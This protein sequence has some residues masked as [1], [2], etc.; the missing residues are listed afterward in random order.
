MRFDESLHQLVDK[1]A[2]KSVF[3]PVLGRQALATFIENRDKNLFYG[4]HRSWQEADEAA[5]RFGTTGYDNQISSDMYDARIRL[6]QHDYPSLYWI[7]RSMQEGLRNVLDLGGSIGIKYLAFREALKPWS[8]MRWSVHDVPASMAHGRDLSAGRGDGAQLGFLDR[9]ED[10]DNSDLLFASGVLQYL[11]KTLDDM[12][13]A[14]RRLPRRIVVNTA[15]IHHQQEYF[16]VNSI[17]TAFC[18]YRVQ[19]Q[20]NLIRSLGALGYKL[21]ESWINPDKPLLIP[22]RPELSL[23]HYSGFCLDLKP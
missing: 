3:R 6:D 9:F 16:T 20:A 23:T 13:G 2:Q 8:D 17:G 21:R 19:T 7:V 12:L 22:F 14:F 1:L 4:V 11:P 10:G 15:A 18:P 5:T